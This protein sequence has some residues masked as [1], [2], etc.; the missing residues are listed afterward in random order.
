[1]ACNQKPCGSIGMIVPHVDT[2]SPNPHISAEDAWMAVISESCMLPTIFPT[3]AN[4]GMAGLSQKRKQGNH[5]K[6][7]PI[8]IHCR[9]SFHW[10]SITG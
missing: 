4:A 10:I 8:P 3:C 1:M 7:G 2:Y 5:L 9:N 6:H